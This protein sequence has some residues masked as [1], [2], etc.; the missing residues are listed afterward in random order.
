M[1]DLETNGITP[2]MGNYYKCKANDIV[3]GWEVTL[4]YLGQRE[5]SHDTDNFEGSYPAIIH[6]IVSLDHVP[7]IYGKP[8]FGMTDAEMTSSMAD[9]INLY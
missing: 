3:N 7:D 5:W 4:Q 8:H 6:E 1:S 9:A 2:V